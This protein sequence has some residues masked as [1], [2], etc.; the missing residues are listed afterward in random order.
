MST[1]YGS[2]R[3]SDIAQIPLS[4]TG[5]L[6]VY[7]HHIVNE[8]VMMRL[9]W[10]L[11][12]FHNPLLVRT[13]EMWGFGFFGDGKHQ[14]ST[15]R[16]T[17]VLRQRLA[18]DLRLSFLDPKLLGVDGSASSEGP[19]ASGGLVPARLA[20]ELLKQ[21]RE[22][23]S[24]SS[25]A[26]AE[27]IVAA[28]FLESYG[29]ED[30]DCSS[31]EQGDTSRREPLPDEEV[32]NG[33]PTSWSSS[34]SSIALDAGFASFLARTPQSFFQYWAEFGVGHQPPELPSALDLPSGSVLC[35]G[36]MPVI[37]TRPENV[38]RY[39]LEFACCF[40]SIY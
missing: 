24:C 1:S 38:L 26:E 37:T 15:T 7:P 40:S 39:Y 35:L 17:S 29:R 12:R 16:A 27:K 36:S 32:D 2:S 25:A 30:E 14:S 10:A 22:I 19:S 20:Y 13:L 23:Q 4:R 11:L 8:A 9:F 3:E 18:S 6:P 5:L 33:G 21:F 31:Q 28:G 34:L